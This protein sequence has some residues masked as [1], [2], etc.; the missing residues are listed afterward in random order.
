VA[1][2]QKH[3]VAL[4]LGSS[5]VCCVV[6][7]VREAAPVEVVGVG[8]APS[9]GIRRGAIVNL[10]A[11]VEALRAA[12]EEAE[13]MAA[14]TV[15]RA[16]VGIAGSHIRGFNSRGVVAVSGRERE[17]TAHDVQ[18]VVESARSIA[19]PPD[20][21]V[22][23]VVPQEF[24]VDDQE[25]I[26]DPAGMTASR[27]EAHVHVVTGSLTAVHNVTACVNR[28]GIEVVDVVL[29]QLAAA[30]SVLTAEDREM[31]AALVD[32]GCGSTRLAVFDRGAVRHTSVVRMGGEH[33]TNDIAVG[34]RTPVAEAEQ[35]KTQYGCALARMVDDDETIGVPSVGGRKPRRLSRQILC[36]ILQPRSEELF[37]LAAEE[38]ERSGYGGAL[39]G[40]VVL[41]GGGSQLEG[42]VEI[43]EQVFD[44]P[45]RIGAPS[46]VGGLVDLVSGPSSSTAV[47]ILLW[48][49]AARRGRAEGLRVP[50][51]LVSRFSSRLKGFFTEIFG[52]G[53][54]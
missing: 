39:S 42:L 5:K 29:D 32:L 38:I 52:G 36:E 31:G 54:R 45:V 13:T 11:A 6:G 34:L 37:A 17:V 22:F 40:G 21:A 16:Y 53:D 28:A 51:Y 35:I 12:V 19:L 47:G 27:L 3:I 48:A 44:L 49:A 15:E 7:E 30:E 23:H 1:S 24:I 50:A 4:D 18:R 33:F 26:G 25:G 46:G 41:T 10:D 43:A 2:R 14:V 8:R 20:R 9:R